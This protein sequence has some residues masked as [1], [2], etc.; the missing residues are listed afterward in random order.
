MTTFLD[1]LHDQ[2][3]RCLGDL[4]RIEEQIAEIGGPDALPTRTSAACIAVLAKAARPMTPAEVHD[5]LS[6]DREV[7]IDAVST[8]LSRLARSGAVERGG[9]GRY[10]TKSCPA[11]I[12]MAV[13]S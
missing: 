5:A 1:Y 9:H 13:G 4:R 8:A 6:T 10:H 3:R 7:S 12:G 11:A 2:K